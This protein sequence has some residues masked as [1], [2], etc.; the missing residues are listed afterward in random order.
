M[1]E[2]LLSSEFAAISATFAETDQLAELIDEFGKLSGKEQD[3]LLLD[4]RRKATR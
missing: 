2:F 4:V 1:S 3:A